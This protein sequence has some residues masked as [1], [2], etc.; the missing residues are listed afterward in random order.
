ML[1]AHPADEGLHS[2]VSANSAMCLAPTKEAPMT[3]FTETQGSILPA[4]DQRRQA[5]CSSGLSTIEME[6]IAQLW[7]PHQICPSET[8]DALSR[9]DDLV[10]VMDSGSGT[11]SNAILANNL[12]LFML[13]QIADRLAIDI[14]ARR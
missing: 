12:N 11:A 14:G 5:L 6:Q 2:I 13:H 1:T 10:A 8:K 3:I 7:H 4:E 9:G